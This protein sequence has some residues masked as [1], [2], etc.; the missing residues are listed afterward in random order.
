MEGD[1]LVINCWSGPRCVSTS[2]MRS[3]AQRS[4]TYV[5]DEPLYA[6][7]LRLNPSLHR[8]YRN[9]VMESQDS[10]GDAV[11]RNTIL[12]PRDR[13]VL[14]VKHMAKHRQG[15]GREL[16]LQG[17]HVLLVRSPEA[18]IRS[19]SEV[20]EPTLHETC[21]TSLLE[22]YSELRSLG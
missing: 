8:P 12:C 13:P 6:H 22:L 2:M 10:D 16:L 9:L 3:F 20:L 5:L 18:V 1:A 14:Y 15:I 21:Y 7:F 17:R 4:D 19:F 11:V